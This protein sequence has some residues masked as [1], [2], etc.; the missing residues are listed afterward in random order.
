MLAKPSLLPIV[1]L[2][3]HLILISISRLQADQGSIEPSR[4]LEDV[5][6]KEL[7]DVY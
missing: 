1:F 4:C 5:S 6:A 7:F 2:V 3:I